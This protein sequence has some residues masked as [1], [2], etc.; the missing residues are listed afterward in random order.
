MIIKLQIALE[1]ALFTKNICKPGLVFL[2][3]TRDHPVDRTHA[4]Q[5]E[6]FL[7]NKVASKIYN[8]YILLSIYDIWPLFHFVHEIYIP[9]KTRKLTPSMV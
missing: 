3:K 2:S 1:T 8:K 7:S 6:Y 4:S 5:M 9:T